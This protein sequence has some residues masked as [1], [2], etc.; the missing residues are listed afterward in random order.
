M[1]INTA[2]IIMTIVSFLIFAGIVAW[3]VA[4]ANRNRF[5]EAA[6]IPLEEDEIESKPAKGARNG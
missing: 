2:R 1:D 4:P 6:M 5:Q 3:V